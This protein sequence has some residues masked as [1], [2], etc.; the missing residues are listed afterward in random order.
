[1]IKVL[2]FASLR[3]QLQCEQFMVV[4]F[5]GQSVADLRTHLLTLN[6]HWHDIFLHQ[7]LL[8][9][10]N[11]TLASAAAPIVDNDEVAF[12]PKVTGG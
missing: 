9:A 7:Q 8:S 4:D 6:P 2:F 10:V 1:M 3:E 11:Q 12:F 5:Q